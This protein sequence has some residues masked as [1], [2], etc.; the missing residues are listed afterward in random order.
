MKTCTCICT[1]AHTPQTHSLRTHALTC[2][3][4][5]LHFVL[6][7]ISKF[8]GVAPELINLICEFS[9]KIHTTVRVFTH[10]G[11]R[12]H[13]HTPIHAHACTHKH[14]FTPHQHARTQTCSYP[15]THICTRLNSVETIVSSSRVALN[16][17]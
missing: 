1:R 14:A 10:V 16:V 4:S 3:C 8:M 6:L 11:S 5:F 2:Q 13:L 7:S 9:I 17:L 15:L 12:K